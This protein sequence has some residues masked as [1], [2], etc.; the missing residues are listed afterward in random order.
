[1]DHRPYIRKSEYADTAVLMIH[2]IMGTPRHFDGFLPLIPENWDVY[3]ILLDGHGKTVRDF[4]ATSMGKWKDQVQAY[5]RELSSRYEKI[6]VIAHSMGTLLSMEAAQLY[7]Q[8]LDKMIFLAP[9]LKIFLR[10]VMI[11]YACKEIFGLI[12]GDDPRE[13]AVS[14]GN[15][16]APEKRVWRYLGNIPRLLELLRLGRQCRKIP[17]KVPCLVFLSGRDELVGVGSGKYLP[18]CETVLLPQSGHFYYTPAE[19]QIIAEKTREFLKEI[20]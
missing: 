5:F 16:I 6:F 13:A 1:M 12:D 14:Q 8:K 17:V 9:P 18:D 2:G 10:P 4:N 7:P 19:W 15:S 20:L 11:K 3:N